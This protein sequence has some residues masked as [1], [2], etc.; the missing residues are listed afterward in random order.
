[1]PSVF[2]RIIDEDKGG[3]FAVVPVGAFRISQKYIRNTNILITSFVSETDSFEVLDFMPRYKTGENNYY[4]APEIYRIIKVIQ[5]KPVII[6]DYNPMPNYASSP[7]EHTVQ[8]DFIKSY[9]VNGRYESVYLYTSLDKN[10]ITGKGKITLTGDSFFLVSYNQKLIDINIHRVNLEFE[11]TLVYWLNWS[12]RARIFPR[13]N[14][15]ILRS[16]LVLKLLTFQKTGA[17]IAACTTSIPEALGEK[18]NWDYRYCWIRD[19][20]MI[21]KTLLSTGHYISAERF[22]NFILSVN[23][24]K[25]EDIRI[26]YGIRGEKKLEE[27]ILHHLNG[28]KNCKPVR[29]GNSAYIQKQNDIYGI[30]I[31]AIYLSITKF[32][33]TLDIAEELWTFVR[34]MIAMVTDNWEKQDRGIWEIRKESKHFVFSKVLSWVALDRGCK[35]ARIIGKADYEKEWSLL[36]WKIKED[37]YLNGWNPELKAFTQAYGSTSLDASL[38]LIEDYGFIEA[39][40]P[41]F[42]STVLAIRDNLTEE[43]MMYRYK[44]KDDFGRPHNSLIIC[45]F[46]LINALWKIGLRG[47]AEDLFEKMLKSSNHLGLF[48]EHIDVKTGE[49]LGN[50]PQGYSHIGLIMAALTINGVKPDPDSEQ[51]IFNKP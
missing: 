49:L 10:L 47:D 33:A 12:N 3:H 18:R 20:S 5:G 45:T 30:L 19:S 17:I 28:Y 23:E 9:S 1:M 22:L 13:F 2:A 14:Q 27:K 7:V 26:M 41:M 39:S 51:F 43:G 4:N 48:S 40:D 44:N 29:K 6:A 21:V 31:D 35:I 46:W 11:R 16:A 42:V 34:G 37:I 25:H 38:L 32:P 24:G 36:K 50:F 15:E 8:H